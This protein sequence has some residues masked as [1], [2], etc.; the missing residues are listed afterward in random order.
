MT[1]FVTRALLASMLLI[2]T[3]TVHRVAAQQLEPRLV[4]S[5]GL[6]SF[7]FQSPSMGVRYAL[8]VGLSFG[9]GPGATGRPG[10][11]AARSPPG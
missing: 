8:N 9:D 6:V 1:L 2:P 3:T 4:P 7:T 11:S 5:R 10:R